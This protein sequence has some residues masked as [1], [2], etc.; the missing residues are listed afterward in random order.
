MYCGF[1][2]LITKVVNLSLQTEHMATSMKVV[3][4]M[5]LIKNLILDNYIIKNYH[6]VSNLPFLSKVIEKGCLKQMFRHMDAHTVFI[7]PHSLHTDH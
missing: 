4:V 2:P 5:P 6:P 1:T 3:P 7:H